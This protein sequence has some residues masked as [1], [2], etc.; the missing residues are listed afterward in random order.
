MTDPSDTSN[1]TLRLQVN[2]EP[3]EAPAGTSLLGLLQQLDEPWGA[4]VVEHNGAYVR[5]SDLDD[6]PLADG[7]RIEVILPAFGG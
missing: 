6:V 3:R 7:G 1:A 5:K 2:G 4:A